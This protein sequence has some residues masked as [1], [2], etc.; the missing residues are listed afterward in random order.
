MDMKQRKN[1]GANN[2][3]YMAG[4]IISSNDTFI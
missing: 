1:D 2:R 4:A 3:L